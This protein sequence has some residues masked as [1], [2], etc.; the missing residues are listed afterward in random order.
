MS[1]SHDSP[2]VAKKVDQMETKAGAA[3]ARLAKVVGQVLATAGCIK[4]PLVLWSADALLLVVSAETEGQEH[5]WLRGVPCFMEVC[6]DWG[7]E[8]PHLAIPAALTHG[9]RG[10]ASLL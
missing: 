7:W 1:A 8:V 5:S 10:C 9:F 3:P 6:N 4:Y 2:K